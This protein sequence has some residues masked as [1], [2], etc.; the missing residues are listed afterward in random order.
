MV[1][2]QDLTRATTLTRM[3]TEAIIATTHLLL[4]RLSSRQTLM[5][6]KLQLLL[7]NRLWLVST[8]MKIPR[9]G[10]I[11]NMGTSGSRLERL[12]GLRGRVLVRLLLHLLMILPVC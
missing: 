9:V 12:R 11:T 6:H 10:E 7:I 8:G 5:D 3:V 1:N 4:N 2:N